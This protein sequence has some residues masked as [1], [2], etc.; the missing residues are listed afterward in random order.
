MCVRTT[1]ARWGSSAGRPAAVR[2]VVR[3]GCGLAAVPCSSRPAVSL[4]RLLRG[5]RRHA[6]RLRAVAR[7]LAEQE[8][9]RRTGQTEQQWR[10][11]V[12]SYIQ[13]VVAS[14]QYPQ[15]AR[16]VVEAEDRS[17]QELFD[18]GLDCL[19]DGLAGRAAGGDVRP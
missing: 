8:A 16:R 2:A 11:S 7:E 15:F 14:G 19:L 5:H 3:R 17:F 12:G 13:E 4:C 18:L 10:A 6:V 1:R 9:Q